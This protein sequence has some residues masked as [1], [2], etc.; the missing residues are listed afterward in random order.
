MSR[1]VE[2]F[3]IQSCACVHYMYGLSVFAEKFTIQNCVN[4]TGNCVPYM[5]RLSGSAEKLYPELRK[6]NGK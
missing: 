4:S 6:F 5:Y 2:K 3:T 1:F